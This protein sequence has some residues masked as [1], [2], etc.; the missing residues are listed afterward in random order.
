MSYAATE[1]VLQ[2]TAWTATNMFYLLLVPAIILWYTY[3]RMSR[4]HMYELA[5]KIPGPKG[6]PLIGNALEF[7]GTSADIFSNVVTK[8]EEF[9]DTSLVKLWIGPRL[10]VFLFDPRDVEVILGSHVHIDKAEDYQFFKPWLGN[11]LLISTGPKWRSH[12]KLIAPTFHLNVLKSFIDLFNA[13]SRAVVDKMKKEAGVFDCHDY[14][15]E[16]TV[17]IL[18]E[19]AMGVSKTTQDQSGYEYA[20]AVMKMCDILHLRHTKIWLR[21]DLLFNFTQYSKVQ[22][23]LLSVIHG[24]TK[25][26]IQK[27]KEDFKSGKQPS[28]VVNPETSDNLSSKVTSV[29]GLSFGQS[30]GLKDDLDVDEDVGQKKRLAFLD[31]LLESAQGG[32]VITDEEIKEQVDTIMFEGH[33][34][35]AAGSSF[36]LSLMGIHQDIQEKVVEELY[37]I[38]GDSDRPATFQDTLEMKYLERCLMETLRM[39]PPVPIIA[40]RLNQDVTMPSCGLQVPAG[41]TVV[42]GTFKLH[43][44]EDVY[45]N[46][47]KFDPDNF[48]PERSA[49]RH[50]YAFVPFSAGPRSCVGRKYAMLKLKI[51]LSTILR[52][53]KVYSDITESEFR[54]QADIILKREEGFKVRLAPRKS[55]AKAC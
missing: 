38:F 51:I 34:T 37:G 32:V 9:N 44:R 7:V 27:K 55:M 33:D 2:S 14:M 35:T 18:L 41:T 52:N 22:E 39:Y 47:N 46:P 15:S 24:L 29:E 40:R 11:G 50:Y 36:F 12:R 19:T 42:V 31:L 8:A 23:K 48:L 17:E 21:P 30:A 1:S 49:N 16:C 4:R 25:K 28:I 20:M 26:V 45:P 13:N 10:L 43:R 53:F 5:E 6:L 3:W 54:L